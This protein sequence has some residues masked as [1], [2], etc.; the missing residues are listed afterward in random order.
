MSCVVSTVLFLHKNLYA[1]QEDSSIHSYFILKSFV[2]D[3]DEVL[4]I[5]L[6]SEVPTLPI[7]LLFSASLEQP[8]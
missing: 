6:A 4:F 3:T 5:S 7:L 8:F 1:T 2:L